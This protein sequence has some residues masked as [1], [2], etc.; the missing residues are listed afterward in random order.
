MHVG[1][2]LAGAASPFGNNRKDSAG[3]YSES[4]VT[5][6][7]ILADPKLR[8]TPTQMILDVIIGYIYVTYVIPI[9]QVNFWP[10][11]LTE[12]LGPA[13]AEVTCSTSPS[14]H[15]NPQHKYDRSSRQL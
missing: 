3:S 15:R 11:L 1:L 8:I 5:V 6:E 14:Q 7:E 13:S 9:L 10:R 4:E 2:L 12:N